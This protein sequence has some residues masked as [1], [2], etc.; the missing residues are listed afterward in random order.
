MLSRISKSSVKCLFRR[1][2]RFRHDVETVEELQN[3]ADWNFKTQ[4]LLN[5]GKHQE[6]IKLLA[7]EEKMHLFSAYRLSI[8]LRKLRLLIKRTSYLIVILIVDR[9]I[10]LI[11]QLLCLLV[12]P[13][14]SPMVFVAV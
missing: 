8:F 9:L 11:V 3:P 7:T 14:E 6:L 4:V 1:P 2:T 5:E 12:R 10:L 13:I